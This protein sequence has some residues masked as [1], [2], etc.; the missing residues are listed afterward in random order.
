MILN[1]PCCRAFGPIRYICVLFG[2]EICLNRPETCSGSS[3]WCGT[4]IWHSEPRRAMSSHVEP[5]R[6]MSSHPVEPCRAMSSHVEPC[7]A[8]SSHPVE[9]CRAMSSHVEPCRATLTFATKWNQAGRWYSTHCHWCEFA[10]K[11]YQMDVKPSLCPQ[12]PS[13]GGLNCLTNH[14]IDIKWMSNQVCVHKNHQ[15]DIKWM[16]SQVC[17][18]PRSPHSL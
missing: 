12:K 4:S 1:L 14:Q 17:V 5:C 10:A 15:M 7:R 6:A 3:F 11:L 18:T 2:A 13:N 16:S 9:P 8:M